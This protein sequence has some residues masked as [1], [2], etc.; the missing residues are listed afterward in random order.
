MAWILLEKLNKRLKLLSFSLQACLNELYICVESEYD[1]LENRV[2]AK[3]WRFRVC[4]EFEKSFES[5]DLNLVT[6][7][8]ARKKRKKL[9]A[10]V[11]W[12]IN[13]AEKLNASTKL[14]L[15]LR[16]SVFR[17]LRKVLKQSS[18]SLAER[19]CN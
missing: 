3:S 19:V 18:L 11:S 2:F 5:T 9:V 16:Y 12:Y 17:V 8:N 1:V 13:Q 15:V 14:V 10:R 4:L 7:L 6:A